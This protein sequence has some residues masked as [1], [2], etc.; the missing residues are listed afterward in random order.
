MSHTR[1]SA[2]EEAGWRRYWDG[3][4]IC[5]GC[6]AKMHYTPDTWRV[7][8]TYDTPIRPPERCANCGTTTL[9]EK[10]TPDA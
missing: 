7:P 3:W 6:I 4:V 2:A 9:P 1:L 8:P 5:P 10:E